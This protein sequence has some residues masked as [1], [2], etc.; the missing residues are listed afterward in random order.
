MADIVRTFFVSGA[1]VASVRARDAGGVALALICALLLGI[2]MFFVLRFPVR[3]DRIEMAFGLIFLGPSALPHEPPFAASK[4]LMDP[5][6]HL[7]TA[8]LAATGARRAF[9]RASALPPD[10]EASRRLDGAGLRFVAL[11]VLLAL[12]STSGLLAHLLGAAD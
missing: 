9:A 5:S 8:L 3:P 7:A 2:E 1:L 11:A 10:G 4:L 12:L 6:H